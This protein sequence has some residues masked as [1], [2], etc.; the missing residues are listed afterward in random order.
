MDRH[1]SKDIINYLYLLQ[2]TSD[3]KTINFEV[4]QIEKEISAEKAKIIR[5]LEQ[6]TKEE[7]KTDDKK[8]EVAVTNENN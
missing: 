4:K 6:K 2:I 3:F 8:V 7:K 5:A 1:F